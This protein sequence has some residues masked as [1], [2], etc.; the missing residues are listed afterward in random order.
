MAAAGEEAGAA[1]TE[2]GWLEAA[3][4][5]STKESVGR[6]CLYII[7]TVCYL[8][9]HFRYKT[10]QEEGAGSS[11]PPAHLCPVPQPLCPASAIQQDI[12]SKKV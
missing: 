1:G 7:Y 12:L 3:T 10:D 6:C 2:E 5:L 11:D 9:S 4:E 8:F